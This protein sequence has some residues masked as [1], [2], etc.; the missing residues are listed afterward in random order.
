M[1]FDRHC[2]EIVTQTGLLRASLPGVDQR[3]PVPSCPGWD[4]NALLRHVGEAHRWIGATVAVPSDT[5]PPQDAVRQVTG[6]TDTDPVALGDWLADGAE[7][8]AATLRRAGPDGPAWTPIPDGLAT[9][10]FHARRMAHE[11][12]MHRADAQ[13]VIGAEF[14][15]AD[16]V[17]ADGIDEWCELGSLPMMFDVHPEQRELLGPGRTILLD[18]GEGGRWMMDMTG[19]RLDFGRT[20]GDETATTT[21]RGPVTDLLLMIFRRKAPGDLDVTVEGDSDLLRFWLDRVSF[22]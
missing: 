15:L 2:T 14:D 19:A 11:T 16:D 20:T 22:A 1:D 21:V 3:A 8:L 12:V 13:L 5:P 10:T 9:A 4:V 7:Q 6:H 17:A 18:G